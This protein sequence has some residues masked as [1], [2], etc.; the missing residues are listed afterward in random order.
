MCDSPPQ[1]R[2]L[3]KEAQ[4]CSVQP[5]RGRSLQVAGDPGTG[6]WCGARRVPLGWR[7]LSRAA[8]G[9]RGSSDGLRASLLARGTTL[10]S[11]HRC[12]LYLKIFRYFEG[13]CPEPI[14]SVVGQFWGASFPGG[15]INRTIK[16][17]KVKA[18]FQTSFQH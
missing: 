5:R 16:P 13:S 9:S 11:P 4:S 7:L 8:H 1:P 6:L 12:S 3:W 15:K 2:Y 17:L 10:S 18:R 14:V